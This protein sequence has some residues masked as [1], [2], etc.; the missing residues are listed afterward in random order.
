M[1]AG[2]RGSSCVVDCW[3]APTEAVEVAARR[4]RSARLSGVGRAGGPDLID[5]LLLEMTCL[6]SFSG[7]GNLPHHAKPD[8]R[9]LQ[10]YSRL[11]NSATG[12]YDVDAGPRCDVGMARWMTERPG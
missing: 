4:T 1:L 3:A 10:H 7:A 11:R 5:Y 2:M 6:T 9:P 12:A 8:Q